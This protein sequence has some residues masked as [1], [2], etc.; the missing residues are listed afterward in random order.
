MDNSWLVVVVIVVVVVVDVVVGI[1]SLLS[2]RRDEICIERHSLLG[3]SERIHVKGRTANVQPQ[4]RIYLNTI[5][6]SGN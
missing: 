3:C 4:T 2:Y 6:P 5:R 1:L